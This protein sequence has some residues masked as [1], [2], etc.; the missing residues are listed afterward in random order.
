MA[1]SNRTVSLASHAE[2]SP[3]LY[4]LYRGGWH[5]ARVLSLHAWGVR[6]ETDVVPPIGTLLVL[7]PRPDVTAGATW[8]LVVA[9]E[10]RRL[11]EHDPSRVG[12][13]FSASWVRACVTPQEEASLNEALDH[14]DG[15][16]DDATGI[17]LLEPREADDVI[18]QAILVMGTGDDG[19]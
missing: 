10:R 6:L 18:R 15:D 4:F 19:A 1:E 7:Q 16:T 3:H 5:D 14:L 12:R 11:P 9:I 2:P 13:A 17:A 8:R